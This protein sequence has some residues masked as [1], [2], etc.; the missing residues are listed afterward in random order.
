MSAKRLCLKTSWKIRLSCFS[1]QFVSF[2]KLITYDRRHPIIFFFWSTKIASDEVLCLVNP[3]QATKGT[4]ADMNRAHVW[5]HTAATNQH[6]HVNLNRIDIRVFQF[7]LV[8]VC[9]VQ[10][11]FF[12][13][14]E[15]RK[16]ADFISLVLYF[17][18]A[19]QIYAMLSAWNEWSTCQAH[20][21][22]GRPRHALV[23]GDVF[24][25]FRWHRLVRYE[26]WTRSRTHQVNV[27]A[28][29]T[30]YSSNRP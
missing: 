4:D 3:L 5:A 12:W 10:H 29:Y 6:S 25:L 16:K 7:V 26:K 21:T 1:W 14:D 19:E 20:S 11:L 9:R 23:C 22:H 24:L 2:H 13:R 18:S 17:K 27:V 28:S 30:V 15:K 8:C